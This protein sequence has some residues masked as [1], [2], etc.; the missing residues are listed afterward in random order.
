MLWRVV[1]Y[2]APDISKVW[3]YTFI[4]ILHTFNVK[5][6]TQTTLSLSTIFPVHKQNISG[7]LLRECYFAAQALEVHCTKETGI[8]NKFLLIFLTMSFLITCHT[9]T[10]SG[11]VRRI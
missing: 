9:W 11:T 3:Y 8:T 10:P 5:V 6:H 4:D 1:A 7:H 2:T